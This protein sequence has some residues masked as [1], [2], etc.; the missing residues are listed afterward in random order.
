VTEPAVDLDDLTF[1]PPARTNGKAT[2]SAIPAAGVERPGWAPGAYELDHRA[3]VVRG[4]ARVAAAHAEQDE[5]EASGEFVPPQL[6]VLDSIPDPRIDPAFEVDG[7]SEAEQVAAYTDVSAGNGR[8]DPEPTRPSFVSIA[9]LE[10]PA[11]VDDWLVQDLL[12]PR[13][14]FVIAAAEDLGKSQLVTE[15][16]IRLATGTGALFDHYPIPAPA[17]VAM[18]NME[19]PPEEA[20]RRESSVLGRLGLE[21]SEATDYYRV[22][23]PDVT[24]PRDRAWLERELDAIRPAVLVIDT[25]T[26][27]VGEEWGPEFK[28]A[29]RYLRGLT[30]RF[31]LAIVIAVHLVK[32]S[33][34]KGRSR[35]LHG[36][37]LSD[38]MGQWGRQVDAV[39]MLADLG[40]DRAR[41]TTKKRTTRAS[42][43]L[44][45]DDGLF[46]VV[47][48]GEER[49][50]ATSAQRVLSAVA[51][52]AGSIEELTAGLGL[53]RST[54][55][56]AVAILRA[57]G[58]LSDELPYRL[59]EA[60]AEAVE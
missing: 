33:R 2:G 57:D 8:P 44:A 40:D 5:L 42:L 31:D 47:A 56:R 19:M 46:K 3:S 4:R 20:W 34:E 41:W 60:G 50:S 6:V 14:L 29:I 30:V 26:A 45:R 48:V 22:D 11:T 59:T 9:Q 17:R 10:Q 13:A 28:A 32:P 49:S 35:G 37:H 15:L 38:V 12:R 55:V 51:A 1:A 54:I 24:L 7:R 23:S 36:E 18:V 43:I 25:G 27:I 39:A 53:S 58:L 52:G 21:R 16:G